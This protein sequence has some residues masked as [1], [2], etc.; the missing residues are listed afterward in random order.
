MADKHDRKIA[1][2]WD[3]FDNVLLTPPRHVGSERLSKLE[4]GDE[5]GAISRGGAY[6]GVNP[7]GTIPPD[8]PKPLVWV[9]GGLYTTVTPGSGG[10]FQR[11]HPI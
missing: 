11:K 9:P 10:C 3:D 7:G 4:S 6:R 1:C 8:Y 5:A 2:F